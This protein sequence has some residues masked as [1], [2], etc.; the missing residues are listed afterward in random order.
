M[1][2][3]ETTELAPCAFCGGA[4]EVRKI[5]NEHTKMAVTIRCP[6]CRVERTDATPKAYNHANHDWLLA[7]ATKNWNRRAVLPPPS[8]EPVQP[9]SI[10]VTIIGGHSAPWGGF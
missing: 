5:G 8:A 7:V 9:D 10:K 1:T 4:P 3:N 2:T 6:D